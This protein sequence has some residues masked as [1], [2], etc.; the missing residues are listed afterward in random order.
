MGYVFAESVVSAV[1][2][3]VRPVIA[4]KAAQV[5]FVQRDHVVQ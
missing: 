3:I 2:L 1:L 5:L 4:N